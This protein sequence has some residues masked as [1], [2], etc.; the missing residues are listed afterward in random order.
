MGFLG[1]IG[2]PFNFGFDRRATLLAAATG[3]TAHGRGPAVGE[4]LS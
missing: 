2:P 1:M 4:G 3:V